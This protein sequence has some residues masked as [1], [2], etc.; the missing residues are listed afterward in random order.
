MK[1][2]I[3][4]DNPDVLETLANYFHGRGH[5]VKTVDDGLECLSAAQDFK[6]NMILLDIKMKRIDGDKIII[7]LFTLLP[8]V[9]I[10]VITGNQDQAL[11]NKILRM[12]IH[13][14]FEKPVSLLVVHQK[15]K[16]ME[17]TCEILGDSRR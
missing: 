1:L 6:P 5:T 14:Y 9:K 2:L 17:G 13:A 7:D 3:V 12:G 11:R 4:D 10:L 8:G 16:E 15:I